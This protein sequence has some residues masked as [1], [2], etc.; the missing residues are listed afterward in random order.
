MTPLKQDKLLRCLAYGFVA[1]SLV[2]LWKF[3][4]DFTRPVPS[5]SG[6]APQAN[7]FPG[8][9][10]NLDVSGYSRIKM[11]MA[12]LTGPNFIDCGSPNPYSTRRAAADSCAVAAFKAHKPFSLIYQ[13]GGRTEIYNWG[14][15]G[16]AKGQV[17]FLRNVEPAMIINNQVLGET[18]Y[19]CKNPVIV[20]VKGQ[21]RLA[22]QEKRNLTP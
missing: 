19:R 7:F 22:C 9:Q 5:T 8:G 21:L 4:R 20:S 18:L 12:Q 16:N 17:F 14:V 3:S 6:V 10:P 13:T 11:A 1:L 15:A 2:P